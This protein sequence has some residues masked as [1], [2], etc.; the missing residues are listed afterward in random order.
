[1]L[2]ITIIYFTLK[3]PPPLNESKK[4]LNRAFLNKQKKPNILIIC[5]FLFKNLKK[6]ALSVE[7]AYTIFI[8]C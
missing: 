4:N 8:S 5:Q 1:M 2:A 7:I 6:D 3:L